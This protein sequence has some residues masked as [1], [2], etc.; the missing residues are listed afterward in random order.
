MIYKI[1]RYRIKR[2]FLIFLIG[3]STISAFAQQVSEQERMRLIEERL[4]NLAVTVNGLNEK[5]QLSVSGVS[6]QEFLRALA[7]SNNLNINIDPSLNFKIYNNFR[8]ETATNVLLFL[9]KQYQLDINIIGSIMSVTKVAEPKVIYQPRDPNIRYQ[10]DK[11]LLSLELNN[12]TLSKVA[13]KI[14]EL[15][16]N[17]II[18]PNNLLQQRITTF[19]SN[20]PFETALEKMAFANNLK[21]IKTADQVYVIQSLSEGEELFINQDKQTDIRRNIKSNPSNGANLGGQNFQIQVRNGIDNKTKLLNVDAVNTSILDL[22]KSS[23]AEAGINYFLYSDIKGNITTKVRNI[24]YN[25]FLSSLFQGTDYTYKVENNIYLIGDRKLEGLR[26]SKVIQLQY[27]SLDTVLAMIPN[28]WRKGVEIKEFKEQNMLLLSGSTPQINEIENYINKIDRLVPMVLI[29]VTLVDIRKGKTIK[30]GIRAGI[31]D[32]VKTGGTILPGI[33]YTFGANAIND[34]LSRIGKNNSFNLG[35]VSP[36]F[37]VGLSALEQNNNVEVRSVPKLST[38]NGHPANL[39]IGSKRYY[40]TRTQN[41]IPSLTT[42]TVVTEQFTPVEANLSIN[43]RPVVSGDDQVTLNI[44]IDISDFIGNPP[45]NQP[46]P[47]STSKFKSIIRAKNEDMIVLGG[48]ERT[49]SS[50]NGDGVPLLSRVPVIKWLF[51]S[52]EKSNT[53]LVTL[54]FIKPTITYQ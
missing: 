39:S 32:S 47:T 12:D 10:K 29:E 14:T 51:S 7:Q 16:G 22:I 52:R 2:F 24:N 54:V 5:V 41:V 18:V 26:T 21:L 48:L 4:R 33:D 37:Y 3:L 46:P 35:R 23:S 15:S 38:L 42:Q 28:D 25:D 30:T 1:P 8:N 20:A 27:R 45:I 17:N 40:S 44:D 13:K 49:E 43:I 34:F 19:L 50:E 6:A 9:A 11:D 53:K 31:S 36:N